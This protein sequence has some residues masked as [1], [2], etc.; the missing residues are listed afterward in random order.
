M[1]CLHLFF[2]NGEFISLTDLNFFLQLITSATSIVIWNCR[3]KKHGLFVSFASLIQK[4]AYRGRT[5]RK[6]DKA[7][8]IG[9][10]ETGILSKYRH[11]EWFS[12]TFILIK[13][14]T[15]FP[16][17]TTLVHARSLLTFVLRKSRQFVIVLVSNYKELLSYLKKLRVV[18]VPTDKW[19]HTTKVSHLF[20]SYSPHPI[21]VHCVQQLLSLWSPLRHRPASRSRILQLCHGEVKNWDGKIAGR[22]KKVCSI[23]QFKIQGKYIKN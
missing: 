11:P 14:A 5:K 10:S 23:L 6:G 17:E 8:R 7:G 2:L 4:P 19:F 20:I 12:S 21:I 15:A 1:C 18:S 3:N 13:T 9:F 22:I 16:A